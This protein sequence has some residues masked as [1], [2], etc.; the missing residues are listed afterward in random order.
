MIPDVQAKKGVPMQHLT[1]LGNFIVEYKPEV[2]VMI[3]D[4]A[5]MPSLSTYDRAGSKA[6]EGKRYTDDIK[7]SHEAMVTLLSPLWDYNLKQKL[8]R[9]AQYRPRMVLTLGNHENRID[10]AIAANPNHLDGMI[11]IGDLE[12]EKYGWEVYPFLQP[13]SIDGVTYCHYFTNPDGFTSNA[14]GGTISN[15]LNKLRTSFVHGHQQTLQYGE[16]YTATGER[17]QGLVAGAYYM[18][19]EEYMGP[20]QNKQH[21]RGICLLDEV[22][23]GSYDFHQFHLNTMLKN[24][25]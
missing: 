15:K 11:S 6:F 13:V 19:D 2:I 10:R 9:K 4:F 16:T 22:S 8:N 12:Y 21:W 25:L 3:G 14:V 7:S 24:Y 17:M 1:A 20:Q 23:N 18:H 5:D